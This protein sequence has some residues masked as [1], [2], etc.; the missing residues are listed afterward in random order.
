[1]KRTTIRVPADLAAS[2]RDAAKRE[3]GAKGLSRW[4]NEAIE[5]YLDA[6]KALDLAGIGDVLHNNRVSITIIL[7]D[8]SLSRIEDAVGTLVKGDP[9]VGNASSV[10]I[11]TSMRWALGELKL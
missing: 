2:I 9:M 8:R 10:L 11:R 7:N 5:R 1:M 4:V 6:D 3:Y